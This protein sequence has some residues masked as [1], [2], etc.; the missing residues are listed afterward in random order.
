MVKHQRLNSMLMV[1]L[2]IKKHRFNRC[3]IFEA[4]NDYKVLM[5][6]WILNY[7]DRAIPKSK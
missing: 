3:F 2:K 7:N 5:G 4:D 1:S 6:I